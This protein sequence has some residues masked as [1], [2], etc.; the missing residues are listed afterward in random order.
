MSDNLLQGMITSLQNPKVKEVVLLQEKAKERER[1][2]LFTVEGL[3]EVSACIGSGFEIESIFLCKE[4]IK[5]KTIYSILETNNIHNIFTVN[6]QVYN[7]IAYRSTTEGIIALVKARH[8]T[9]ENLHQILHIPQPLILVAEGVEKP[10]NLGAL[11]RTADA[12]GVT[13]V[14][15]CNPITDLY[16]PNLIRASLGGVFTQ[17]IV[18]CSSQEAI[19]FLKQHGIKIYTA[20]LQ[21]SVPYYDTDM[22]EPCAIVMGSEANGLTHIWRQVSDRKIMIPMLGKLDSLNVSVS[23]SILCYEAIRQRNKVS[24]QPVNAK[25]PLKQQG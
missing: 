14:M 25:L 21:D 24:K 18:C 22:T 17:T 12:C 9:L 3:R 4:I 19:A 10:G 23:A 8:T 20:Q 5:D 16:N 2:G 6:Q 7:K 11:L 1:K 15:F 13:A